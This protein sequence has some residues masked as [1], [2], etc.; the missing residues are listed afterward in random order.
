MTSEPGQFLLTFIVAVFKVFLHQNL[1]ALM[2]VLGIWKCFIFSL[3]VK[4]WN[5]RL[6]SRL[7]QSLTILRLFDLEKNKVIPIHY[8]VI[9]LT[10]KNDSCLINY[11]NFEMLKRIL[12]YY[13]KEANL[14]NKGYEITA[15]K[16][17]SGCDLWLRTF[18]SLCTWPSV[19]PAYPAPVGRPGRFYASV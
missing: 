7:H 1:N 9:Y 3:M 19:K 16:W 12:S 18:D 6:S 8:P 17:F 4:V 11:F 5:V 13:T 15:Q 14:Q 2:T 10:Y